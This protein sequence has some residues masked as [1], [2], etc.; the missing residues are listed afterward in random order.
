MNKTL[1]LF[2]LLVLVTACVSPG[3][4][5]AIGA[6]TGAAVGAGV[7]AVIGHQSGN[8][9]Q[10]AAIGAGIG[11]LLGA[12][13]GN[14]LD[15]QARELEALAETRRTE[16]GIVTTLKDSLLFDSGKADLKSAAIEN[17]EKITDILKKYPENRLVVVGYTDST[18]TT[19]QN[20][21]LSE[22]RAQAVRLAMITR[23]L[24][25][26]VVEAVGQGSSNPV[27]PNTTAEGRAKN[28]RVELLIS[29]ETPK[30]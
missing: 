16:N 9:G 2:T 7:G 11:A 12:G 1:S 20:Q 25:S 28:R 19:A 4:K 23:G 3:K 21:R 6:G 15:R 24:S 8:K 27:A 13:V 29:A 10:G 17:I 14:R 18:G 5:T 26:S 22:R 30:K